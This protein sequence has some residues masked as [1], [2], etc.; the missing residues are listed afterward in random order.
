MITLTLTST[1]LSL[2]YQHL[3]NADIARA[4]LVCRTWNWML[5]RQTEQS[6]LWVPRITKTL[7]DNKAHMSQRLSLALSEIAMRRELKHKTV[8][9]VFN[10]MT[11][12]TDHCNKLVRRAAEGLWISGEYKRVLRSPQEW[13]V[14]RLNAE[15]RLV[16]D[17][18]N[19]EGI[20]KGA[21][22]KVWWTQSIT[23]FAYGI[24]GFIGSWP[25]DKTA[26]D[27]SANGVLVNEKGIVIYD[28][29]WASIDGVPE[30]Y[31]RSYYEDSGALQIRGNFSRSTP[32][33]EAVYYRE[34]GTLL[35]DGHWNMGA[36]HGE[37]TL[38]HD[39]GKTESFIGTFHNK[40]AV[41]GS[42]FATDGSLIHR[43]TH[44]ELQQRMLECQQNHRCTYNITR[45]SY[46][47][48][49]WYSCRTC[50]GNG[51]CNKGVCVSCAGRC[52]KGHD[53]VVKQESSFF[54]DCG[55][56]NAE[57]VPCVASEGCAFQCECSGPEAVNN[58]LQFQGQVALT[59]DQQHAYLVALLLAL[60]GE[61]P[62]EINFNGI[63]QLNADQRAILLQQVEAQL[64]M[65]A[66]EQ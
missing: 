48:Q 8:N 25:S 66:N 3:S 49:R 56:K 21:A 16:Y 40:E 50:F 38:Y 65:L 47:T 64:A 23:G 44:A 62:Q 45:K 6:V 36:Q 11:L 52:H 12:V 34:D 42:W 26:P 19:E 51:E 32:H 18:A 7:F 30:G 43:G 58:Q 54:C 2:I 53:L 22:Y 24:C 14:E 17:A 59:A 39:D 10:S 13:R 46:V 29:T 4:C 27:Q 5:W 35:Y 55:D 33:G 28:G 60:Q 57:S 61:G 9:D 31:G 20:R 63:E 37:G 1:E 15:Q 41:Q